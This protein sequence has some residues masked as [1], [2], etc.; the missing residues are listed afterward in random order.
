MSE[1]DDEVRLLPTADP[2][3]SFQPSRDPV[4]RQPGFPS[5]SPKVKELY[6]AVKAF[7]SFCEAWLPILDEPVLPGTPGPSWILG[8]AGVTHILVDTQAEVMLR[9][10]LLLHENRRPQFTHGL[11]WINRVLDGLL[12][13]WTWPHRGSRNWIEDFI[14]GLKPDPRSESKWS[15]KGHPCFSSLALEKG[16]DGLLYAKGIEGRVTRIPTATSVAS[17]TLDHRGFQVFET[18][19]P[20]R[21][22][23]FLVLYTFGDVERQPEAFLLTDPPIPS[24]RRDELES[25]HK[26]LSMMK[27]GYDA[28][29]ILDVNESGA[30]AMGVDQVDPHVP[31]ACWEDL[32]T[33]DQAAAMVHK[34]K[35]TLERYKTRGSLPCPAVEGGGGRADLFEWSVLRTWL[36]GEFGIQLPDRYPRRRVT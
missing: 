1:P 11:E 30:V 33:L 12:A 4:A 35:R 2:R 6:E 3:S 22:T 24:I 34:S 32:V 27:A 28:S 15:R 26:A 31:A 36:T 29:G 10:E 25:L 19:K 17:I 14:C 23:T 7:V 21:V 5:L 8:L 20:G 18:T 9:D 13:R 16:N